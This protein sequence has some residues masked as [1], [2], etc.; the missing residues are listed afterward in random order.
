M[1]VGTFEHTLDPKCRVVLPALF[2]DRLAVGGFLAKALDGGCLS[3]WTEVD[4][5]KEARELREKERAGE[6]PSSAVRSLLAGAAAVKPDAQ[7]R[8]A[9]PE[10]LRTFAGLREN[11]KVVVIGN[12]DRIELWAAERWAAVDAS[13][14]AILA[15]LAGG[16]ARTNG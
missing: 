16:T 3:L 6:V 7:G 9:V 14:E 2:R 4:F 10:A 8:I 11:D 13:G 15:G 5:E 1:F 12:F